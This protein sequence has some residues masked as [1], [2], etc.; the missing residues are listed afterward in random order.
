MKKCILSLCIVFVFL[1][2]VP[3]SGSDTIGLNGQ[4]W[5]MGTAELLPQRRVE[6]GIFQPLRYGASDQ[7]EIS[8]HP[9]LFFV[10]PNVDIKWAHG[11][12]GGFKIASAHGITY[13]SMLVNWV[14]KEGIGGL[15]SPEFDIPHIL[16]FQNALLASR[17]VFNGHLFT[18]KLALNVAV[19]SDELDSRTTIDLPVVYPRM[20]I[21]YNDFGFRVGADVKGPLFR[22]F[23]YAVDAELFYYPTA[24][25]VVNSAFEHKG[26]L[27]WN[28]SSNVQ[29]CV[30]Y[31]LTYGEYPFGTQWHL[32][33][34]VDVQWG[35]SRRDKN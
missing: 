3:L 35:W 24:E 30:G 4:T 10:M 15:I 1:A 22:R 16:S 28:K 34:L 29:F 19:R 7:L 32:L 27:Y 23:S 2:Y 12:Y 6:I 26:L 17:G 31:L 11:E 20:S 5:S 25:P 13:P 21:Y 8:L 18:G 33:P 9:L 14:A